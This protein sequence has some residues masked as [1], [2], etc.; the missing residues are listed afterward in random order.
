MLVRM[1]EVEFL[2]VDMR[3]AVTLVENRGLSLKESKTGI[4]CMW[5]TLDA[6]PEDT[7]RTYDHST[8]DHQ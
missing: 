6:G 1:Q 3:N 2:L 8:I 4:C 5:K 7:L